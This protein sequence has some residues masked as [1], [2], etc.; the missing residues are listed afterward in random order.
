MAD[1]TMKDS[2]WRLVAI[3][4]L[5]ALTGGATLTGIGGLRQIGHHEYMTRRDVQEAIDAHP[6]IVGVQYE[7]RRISKS[8]EYIEAEMRAL[9][10]RNVR[11]E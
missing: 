10:K 5:G 2:I 11:V 1:Y 4:A 9:S 3:A 7:L 6:A 8:L